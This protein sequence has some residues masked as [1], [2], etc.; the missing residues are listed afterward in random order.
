MMYKNLSWFYICNVGL[1]MRGTDI[2]MH[3]DPV[4]QITICCVLHVYI[5][6]HILDIQ[7]P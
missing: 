3:G 7:K 6:M 5:A 2:F 1:Y 4:V